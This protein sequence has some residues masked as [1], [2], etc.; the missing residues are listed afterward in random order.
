MFKDISS[1]SSPILILNK[2]SVI[3]SMISTFE[4]SIN[5]NTIII[6][7]FDT[8]NLKSVSRLF[9][10]TRINSIVLND[11]NTSKIEDM[12]YIFDYTTKES[13]DLSFFGTKNVRNMS[14]MFYKSAELSS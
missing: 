13:L 14:H 12:S 3:T 4:N 9:Y 8:R 2:N 10:N 6:N 7:G 1:L 11:F 5:L